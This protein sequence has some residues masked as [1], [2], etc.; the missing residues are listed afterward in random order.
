MSYFVS[1][2][3]EFL[4]IGYEKFLCKFP[5]SKIP[6]T[7]DTPHY[8]PSYERLLVN[9]LNPD[10]YLGF[11]IDVASLNIEQYSVLYNTYFAGKPE[12]LRHEFGNQNPV[13]L[14][15]I[16]YRHVDRIFSEKPN[17]KGDRT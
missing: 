13:S 15:R 3:H 16:S 11:K 8:C 2:K 14:I 1:I 4:K 17:L 12:E 5:D 10:N 7:S 9:N 6:V